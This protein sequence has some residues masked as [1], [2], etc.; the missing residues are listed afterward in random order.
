MKKGKWELRAQK[1]RKIGKIFNDFEFSGKY[2][3]I[4]KHYSNKE[5]FEN[6]KQKIIQEYSND[7]VK[8]LTNSNAISNSELSFLTDKITMVNDYLKQD[9]SKKVLLE[10]TPDG[11]IKIENLND[12][13]IRIL[14]RGQTFN[15]F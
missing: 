12:F 7:V 6:F 9:F 11:S 4:L 13:T 14:S 3:F 5:F 15:L 1:M 2:L 8:Q 10:K